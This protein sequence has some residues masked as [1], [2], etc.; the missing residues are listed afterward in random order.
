MSIFFAQDHETS[1]VAPPACDYEFIYILSRV[2]AHIEVQAKT[3]S[4]LTECLREAFIL[5][6]LRKKDVQLTHKGSCYALRYP[7][8]LQMIENYCERQ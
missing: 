1:I 3:G 2:P 5:M 7:G 4:A 8:L 6:C